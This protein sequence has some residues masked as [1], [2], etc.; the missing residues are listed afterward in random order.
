MPTNIQLRSPYI[1]SITPTANAF[2]IDVRIFTNGQAQDPNFTFSKNTIIKDVSNVA[3]GFASVDISDLCRDLIPEIEYNGT[4]PATPY[5]VEIDDVVFDKFDQAGAFISE[6]RFTNLDGFE[7]YTNFQD[8]LNYAIPNNSA[9]I[10]GN[11]IWLPIGVGTEIYGANGS[12]VITKYSVSGT[13]T[14]V[15]IEGNTITVRRLNECKYIHNKITFLNKWGAFQDLWFFTKMTNTT[16]SSNSSY[17]ASVLDLIQA[18][19]SY[20]TTSHYKK[21]YNSKGQQK[22][23]LST[24]IVSEDYNQY[25]Q[26]LMMSEFIWLTN[27]IGDGSPKPVNLTSSELAKK[28]SLNDNLVEYTLEFELSNQ[29]INNIR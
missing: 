17:Q 12:G 9:L 22:M 16:T 3:T 24:G 26:E 27:S 23:S 21:T 6:D 13:D 1:L 20:S 14:S 28:T 10:S 11:L 19:P 2:F 5:K 18:N 15:I 4:Y 29:L 25:I 8:G 7:A